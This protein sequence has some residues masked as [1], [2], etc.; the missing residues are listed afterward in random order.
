MPYRRLPNTDEQRL[1]ALQLAFNK[2]QIGGT[3][4]VS[5]ILAATLTQLAAFLPDYERQLTERGMALRGQALGTSHKE[6][7]KATGQMYISHFIQVFNLAVARGVYS[8][9]DRA[10]YQLDVNQESVPQLSAEGDVLI[11][12]ERI[13]QGENARMQAG[14][15]E[16]SN[17]S[18]GEVLAAK[19][20][21]DLA[22]GEASTAK[23]QYD[24]EAEDV[25]KLRDAADAL[26]REIWDEIEFAFRHS[27]DAGRRRKARE[28]GVVFVS[29]PGETAEEGVEPAPEG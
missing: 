23:D 13:V 19:E 20:A 11:W 7:A 24:K 25:E 27:D 22:M 3:N 1:L 2:S 6:V 21:F 12:L 16:M 10:Y 9:A 18:A 4:A 26:I 14:G 17:P 28:W 15:Q 5:P 8:A 29:R